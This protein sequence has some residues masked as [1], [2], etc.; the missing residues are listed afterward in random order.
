MRKTITFELSEEQAEFLHAT[1]EREERSVGE[2]VG[3]FV[4]RQMDYDA[5]FEARVQEGID[6]IECGRVLTHEDVK[7]RAALRRAEL[8]AK[9]GPR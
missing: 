5:W 9:S 2:V 6:D 7:R 4:Q 1:A 3:D 8:T